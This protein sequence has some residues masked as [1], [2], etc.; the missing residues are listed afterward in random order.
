M[1]YLLDTDIVSYLVRGNRDVAGRLVQVGVQCAISAVTLMELRSWEPSSKQI[2]EL[3]E[4]AIEHLP[5][6]D[7]DAPA[8]ELTARIRRDLRAGG[9]GYSISDIMIAAT[10]IANNLILVSNNSKDFESIKNLNFENWL[11]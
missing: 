2:G 11:K 8:A 10:A 7:F 9:K 4:S 5:V 1:R 3:I 6:V